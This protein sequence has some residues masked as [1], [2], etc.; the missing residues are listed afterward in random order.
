MGSEFALRFWLLTKT[1][2]IFTDSKG[3]IRVKDAIMTN[4]P[5]PPAMPN[6]CEIEDALET[7]FRPFGIKRTSHFIN[8]AELKSFCLAHENYK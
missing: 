2:L 8:Y 6:E 3:M 5:R 7:C 4:Q 1:N